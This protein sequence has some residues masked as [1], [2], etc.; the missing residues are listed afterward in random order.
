MGNI[1]ANNYPNRPRITKV[2]AKIKRVHFFEPQCICTCSDISDEHGIVFAH[3]TKWQQ[4]MLLR[5]GNHVCVIDCTHN[6]TAYGLPLFLLC[7]PTNCGYITA[8]SLLLTDE[9]ACTVEE[10]LRKVV[11]WCPD[12]RPRCVLSDFS[13]AQIAAVEAVFE[14]NVKH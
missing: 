14:G 12:W 13:E 9:Q 5:Y 7:V 3:Q 4:D 2:I 1:S 11:Q 6:T 8:A 10:G